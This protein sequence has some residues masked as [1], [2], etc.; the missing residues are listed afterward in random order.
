MGAQNER[1]KLERNFIRLKEIKGRYLQS[2]KEMA[3]AHLRQVAELESKD[4][5]ES[6]KA[7]PDVAKVE[8]EQELPLVREEP[9][10]P[11]KA[12]VTRELDP[13]AV[14]PRPVEEART[15]SPPPTIEREEVL[16]AMATPPEKSHRK[17]KLSVRR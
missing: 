15:A 1:Q 7:V 5:G 13:P 17:R 4:E 12:P 9:P 6:A 11:E 14:Q 3:E 8:G 2:L 10:R 16:K